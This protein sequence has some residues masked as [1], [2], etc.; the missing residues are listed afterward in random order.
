[1]G[2]GSQGQVLF[3]VGPCTYKGEP[4]FHAQ[5]GFLGSG[6]MDGAYGRTAGRAVGFLLRKLSD[7]LM[8]GLVEID[9]DPLPEGVTVEA[10]DMVM[11]F[12]DGDGDAD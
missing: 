4:W 2:F 3:E 9:A 7:E 11:T 6:H 8:S 1:M 10:C 5:G 12:Q